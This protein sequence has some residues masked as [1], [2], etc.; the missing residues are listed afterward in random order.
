MPWLVVCVGAGEA[1]AG[2][3][4]PGDAARRRAAA[5]AVGHAGHRARGVLGGERGFL[6]RGGRGLVAVVQVEIGDRC[7][8]SSRSSGASPAHWSSGASRAIAT[9]RSTSTSIAVARQVAGRHRRRSPPDEHAQAQFL[10]LRP[11]D[12]LERA[13]PHRHVDAGRCAEHRVGGVGAGGAG[14]G[15]DVVGAVTRDV[16]GQHRADLGSAEPRKVKKLVWPTTRQAR[17]ISS[18]A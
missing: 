9:A 15:N 8:L 18:P 14:A 4:R 12:I 13:E 3:E 10:F 7:P 5:F 1:V 11:P 2:G 17:K 6:E 16:G